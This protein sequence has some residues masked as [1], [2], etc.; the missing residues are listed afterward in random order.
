MR[1]PSLVERMNAVTHHRGP[2][3][4][5]VWCDDHVTLGNDRLAIIDIS[6]AGHQP[7]ESADG[8]YIIVFNGEIYNYRELKQSLS[9]YPFK[10]Q[11]DT[12]VILAGFAKWGVDIF[13][14]LNGVF[15]IAVWDKL[16]RE[17]VLARDRFGVKPL[18]FFHDGKRFIF[19]SE[20]K[21]LLLHD[22]PRA[23]DQ[24]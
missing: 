22:I 8:R 24:N 18:Y 3:D 14:R 21:A 16:E 9:R 10:S 7:M 12:E 11:S 5:G 17:L 13:H 20:L 15:A 6:P 19:S 2:D 1:D 23:I 4:T